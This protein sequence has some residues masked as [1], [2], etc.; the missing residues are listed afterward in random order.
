MDD[1]SGRHTDRPRV[2][3]PVLAFQR[4]FRANTTSFDLDGAFHTIASIT[5]FKRK[6]G[7]PVIEFINKPSLFFPLFTSLK[8][9]KNPATF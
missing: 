4:F 3:P 2:F 7:N 6:A 8:T 9:R 5:P 1:N